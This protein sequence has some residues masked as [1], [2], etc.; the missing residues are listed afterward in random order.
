M[1][2]SHEALHALP[3]M[4]RADMTRTA[5]KNADIISPPH[6][7]AK[8]GLRRSP[9]VPKATRPVHADAFAEHGF[10]HLRNVVPVALVDDLRAHVYETMAPFRKARKADAEIVFRSATAW[11]AVAHATEPTA[12]VERTTK[13]ACFGALMR[14]CQRHVLPTVARD[15]LDLKHDDH[16]RWLR[17]GMP[18]HG[19][20]RLPAHQDVFYLKPDLA[21]LTVWVPLHP[22]PAALG[23]LRVVPG[24]HRLGPLMHNGLAGIPVRGKGLRWKTFAFDVGDALVFDRFTIHSSGLNRSADQIRFSIDFR[25]VIES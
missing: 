24:S 3:R 11:D 17:I 18:N 16:A 21:F 15:P 9:A 5:S 6:G 10:V 12:F 13:S 25:L 1:S 20:T 8:T 7:R 22:C 23:G 14:H 2:T 19:P 4:S